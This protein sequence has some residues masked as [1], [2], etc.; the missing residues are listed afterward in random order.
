MPKTRR[1]IAEAARQVW[2]DAPCA[3]SHDLETALVRRGTFRSW[4]AR[5]SSRG[6]QRNGNRAATGGRPA[7][8]SRRSVAGAICCRDK[9]AATKSAFARSKPSSIT[10]IATGF[11]PPLGQRIFAR[12][13]TQR[14]R[15]SQFAWAQNADKKTS[16]RWPLR[17]FAAWHGGDK[18]ARDILESAAHTLAQDAVTCAKRLSRPR[19]AVHFILTGS[20]LLK[21][22][23][24][25]RKVRAN[26]LE[27][28]Q[29][30]P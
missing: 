4:R 2:P 10:S 29:K 23:R 7:A 26:I 25:G 18:I 3:V 16:P 5:D 20:V 12:D 22:P 19:R 1:G 27:L 21:Q 14:T 24:F 30:P 8:R 17:F 6:P 15:R 9:A 11:W 13:A 28:W